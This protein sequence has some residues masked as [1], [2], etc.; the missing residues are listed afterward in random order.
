MSLS[1][2]VLHVNNLK[3]YKRIN[4]VLIIFINYL[5]SFVMKKKKVLGLPHKLKYINRCCRGCTVLFVGPE[6]NKDSGNQAPLS[7]RTFR[8]DF[9][10]CPR[11][12][13]KP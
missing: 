1:L 2:T 3:P 9:C 5:P 10:S 4:L 12:C 11:L 8:S 7:N 6:L 13:S